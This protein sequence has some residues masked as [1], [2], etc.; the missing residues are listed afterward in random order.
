MELVGEKELFVGENMAR[1]TILKTNIGTR[2]LGTTQCSNGSWWDADGCYKYCNNEDSE[3]MR[4][5]QASKLISISSDF[6]TIKAEERWWEN[7]ENFVDVEI[8]FE[9]I[10]SYQGM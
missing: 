1:V 10:Q 6:G 9:T 5:H 7:R 3:F 2:I 4:R 8:D